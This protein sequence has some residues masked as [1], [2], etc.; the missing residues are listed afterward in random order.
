MSKKVVQQVWNQAQVQT[1]VKTLVS[2]EMK[3]KT[4]A[5]FVAAVQKAVGKN[6][7]KKE[8]SAQQIVS[9]ARLVRKK[10]TKLGYNIPEIPRK[11]STTALLSDSTIKSLAAEL[12]LKKL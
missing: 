9:K 4:Q 7:L 12:G 1:L 6:A 8:F 5:E 10:F 11:E 2:P 3:D